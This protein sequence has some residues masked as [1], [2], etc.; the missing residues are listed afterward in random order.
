MS[1]MRGLAST[2]SSISGWSA[3]NWPSRGSSQCEAKIGT[4][5]TR[6]RRLPEDC[7]A[8][9]RA[10]S[11]KAWPVVA[12]SAVPAGASTTPR[13]PRSNSL[14]P[15]VR[16][17]P[18]MRWLTADAVMCN[19]AAAALNEPVRA[20]S[21]KACSARR[22]RAE[23]VTSSCAGR[24][25]LPDRGPPAR[26]CVMSEPEARG[27]EEHELARSERLGRQGH[28]GGGARLDL[29]V[30]RGRL[31]QHAGDVEARGVELGLVEGVVVA[32]WPVPCGRR[33]RCGPT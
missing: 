18:A 2:C 19:A 23:R 21:S 8:R 1:A 31:R 32:G 22:S 5:E 33:R 26:S 12:A 17:R 4:A 11:P 7:R 13:G 30:E 27:P 25:G 16:S 10:R 29:M 3:R 20:A 24:H 14:A 9:A 28:Q 15:S 6:S